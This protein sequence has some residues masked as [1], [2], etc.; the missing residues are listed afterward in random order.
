MES[1]NFIKFHFIYG[2][3]IYNALYDK[4]TQHVKTYSELQQT[5]DILYSSITYSVFNNSFVGI[6]NADILQKILV[7][8]KKKD[9]LGL[10]TLKMRVN[11]PDTITSTD[12]P[13]LVF[14]NFKT[15]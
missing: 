12:N 8:H 1:D 4:T 2:K 9:S 3:R 11:L 13:L 15:F 6:I 7:Y 5:N 10:N 14:I